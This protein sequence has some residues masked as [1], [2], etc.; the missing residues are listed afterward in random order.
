LS[1]LACQAIP[2]SILVERATAWA[3]ELGAG[4]LVGA[5]SG[6]IVGLLFEVLETAMDA[7]DWLRR[8]ISGDISL[9]YILG[10]CEVNP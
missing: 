4:G 9:V 5:H 8:R 3:L 2:Y 7:C 1:A 6:A 10:E